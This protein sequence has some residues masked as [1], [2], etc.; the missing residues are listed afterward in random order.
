M[1]Q[2]HLQEKAFCRMGGAWNKIVKGLKRFNIT[3]SKQIY[4]SAF[5]SHVN[6]CIIP[7]ELSE[8]VFV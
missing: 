1:T 3:V 7:K 5:I 8:D 4:I 2:Q 6:N